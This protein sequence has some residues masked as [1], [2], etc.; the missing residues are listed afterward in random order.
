MDVC[1]ILPLFFSDELNLAHRQRQSFSRIVRPSSYHSTF[2]APLMFFCFSREMELKPPEV[3]DSPGIPPVST[4][5]SVPATTPLVPHSTTS[6][7]TSPAILEKK[8]EKEGKKED[9]EDEDNNEI[10][11]ES[12][13]GRWQKRREQVR[14]VR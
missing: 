4:S 12:P 9:S 10:L 2:S 13:C 3:Q 1:G 8:E 5:S 11:E 6:V 7:V 14:L